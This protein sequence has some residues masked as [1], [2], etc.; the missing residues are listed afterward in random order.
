VP[1]HQ[2]NPFYLSFDFYFIIRW[3]WVNFVSNNLL[4]YKTKQRWN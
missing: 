4:S 1:F 3:L 2:Q